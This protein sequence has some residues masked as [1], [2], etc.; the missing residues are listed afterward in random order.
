MNFSAHFKVGLIAVS[1]LFAAMAW[2][3]FADAAPKGKPSETTERSDLNNDGIVDY[4]DLVIFSSEYLEDNVE[5]VDWCAFVEATRLDDTLYGR[6]PDFYIKHFNQLLGFISSRF[7]CDLSDL[8]NDGA[9]NTQ[10]LVIFSSMYLEL[11][12][13]LV[14]WCAFYE[15]TMLEERYNG[16][17]TQYYLDRFRL[18]LGYIFDAFGC[19]SIPVFPSVKNQPVSLTRMALNEDILSDYFGYIYISDARLGSVFI[20]NTSWFL[21]GEI[22]N[23]D[24]PLGI[25]IDSQGYLLVGNNG[26]N[27]IEVYDPDNGDLIATFGEGLVRMPTAITIGSN[28]DIYVTDSKAHKV[29]VFESSYVHIRT[30][31]IPGTEDGQL[32]FPVDTAIVTRDDSGTSVQE[33]YIAD[34]GNHRIQVFDL[35]GSFLRTIGPVLALSN[36]CIEYG[37]GCPADAHGTFNRL[38]ALDVDS[39]GRLHALDIFEA[40]VTIIDP[41]SG[42]KLGSYGSWGTDIGQ[43]RTPL[44]VLITNSGEAMVTD[45]NTSEVE[46]FAI[47]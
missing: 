18:L 14:E 24:K 13:E 20:Y 5:T 35:N 47:P 43:L 11:N 23:L 28:G 37:F 45:N 16:K 9:I 22:E 39:L 32:K 26:R 7:G 40:G 8:N 29:W 44:D 34:Q 42:A 12:W 27:N 38:Q 33:I 4:D 41:F 6:K 3:P 21:I 19:D 15:A 17:I 1:L 46:I 36:W 31:G 30:I 2:A 25:A 10:D